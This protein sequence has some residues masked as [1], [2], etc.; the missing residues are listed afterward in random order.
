MDLMQFNQNPNGT[1]REIR[2]VQFKIYM[3]KQR[4]K[5]SQ[6]TLEEI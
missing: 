6:H 5:N 1:I 3:K 2:Q 4:S